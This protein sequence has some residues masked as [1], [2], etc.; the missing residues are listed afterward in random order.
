M[1]GAPLADVISGMFAAY[2]IVSALRL[3]TDEGGGQYIDLSMQ[4]ALLAAAG[5]RM[6]ETLQA[7]IAPSS[8]GKRKSIARSG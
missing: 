7:G 3:V 8:L 2:T 4:D 5:T 6:G 1:V